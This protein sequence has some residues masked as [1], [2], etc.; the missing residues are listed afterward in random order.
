MTSNPLLP[1]RLTRNLPSY[2]DKEE[3][4]EDRIVSIGRE[5]HQQQ[6]RGY[7]RLPFQG[8]RNDASGG[9]RGRSGRYFNQY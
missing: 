4:N 3:R 2:G 5:E 7:G 1:P 8:G 9:Y 6:A